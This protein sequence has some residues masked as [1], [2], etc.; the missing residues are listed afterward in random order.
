M[1][2]DGHPY[3][4]YICIFENG[5]EWKYKG[6]LPIPAKTEATKRGTKLTCILYGGENPY[7]EFVPEICYDA[8]GKMDDG[9]LL[10]Q[11]LLRMVRSPNPYVA[12]LAVYSIKKIR[13]EVKDAP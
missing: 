6:V 13:E 7:D 12:G 4:Y 11:L 9:M 5:E 10:G 2:P 3:K 8:N 1:F